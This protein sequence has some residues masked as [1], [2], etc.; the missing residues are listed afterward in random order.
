M[1]ATP[2]VR[3]GR[4]GALL[5]TVLCIPMFLILLD[6]MA[7]N[8]AMPTLGRA[9]AISTADWAQVVD[10]YTV[11]LAIGLLP[12]GLI[13]DRWGGRRSLL[14]A[15]VV[16]CLASVLGGLAWSW[17]VVLAAR[18]AQGLAAAVMLPAGLA[19]LTLTWSAPDAR[20]RALGAWSAVSAVATA[21]GPAV[22]GL[23]VAAASWRSVFWVN[24]P[25]VLVAL[26]G[27][28]LLLPDRR[29]AAGVRQGGP[30]AR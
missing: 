9:F 16:F 13:V 14:T 7:M 29:T 30:R 11:P 12:G 22:G 26:F 8:V 28:A 4:G 10:A 3:D 6:V 21:V 19:A 23:L 24:V 25:L 2:N 27:T 15:L 1:D 17:P 18:V 20:A 5:L